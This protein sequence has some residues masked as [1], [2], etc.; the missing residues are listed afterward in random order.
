MGKKE[1]E[2]ANG[3]RMSNQYFVNIYLPNRVALSQISVIDGDMKGCG[4]LI[5][6]DIIGFGDFAIT[7]PKGKTQMSFCDPSSRDIDFVKEINVA[8]V[9]GGVRKPKKRKR[10]KRR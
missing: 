8:R 3:K 9:K 4:I 5:G 2:T 6:M 1:V 7:H 10:R